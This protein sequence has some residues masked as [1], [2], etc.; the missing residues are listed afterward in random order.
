MS[1]RY[2]NKRDANERDIIDALHDERKTYAVQETN[3]D[4][5]T[6][7]PGT[8]FWIPMEVK[9]PNGRLTTKQKTLHK[10]LRDT[11]G[12]S[13]PII[14]NEQEALDLVDCSLEMLTKL[15]II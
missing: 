15:G 10:L 14:K 11:Y 5:Y 6:L 12:Y 1:G 3:I 13:V 2:A 4:L 7:L 8:P 9:M